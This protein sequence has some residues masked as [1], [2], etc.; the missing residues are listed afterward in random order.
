MVL[1]ND[2]RTNQTASVSPTDNR[3]NVSS[4]SDDRIFYMSRD[5]G[6]AYTTVS[7]DTPS[8]ADEYNFYFQN[9]D[10]TKKFYVHSIIF[11]TAVLARFKVSKVTGTASGTTITPTNLNT[12]FGDNAV[13]T[14]LG[15]AA[16][17]GLT[18]SAVIAVRSVGADQSEEIRF[19]DAFIIGKGEAF[20]IEYDVGAGGIIDITVMGFFETA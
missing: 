1:I 13:A 19:D 20:A 15:N 17:T 2:G 11:G 14:V 4:R 5:N 16:V 9:D 7:L 8:A 12:L 18:E 3:L 10:T 6:D